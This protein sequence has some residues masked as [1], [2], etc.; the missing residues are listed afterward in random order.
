MNIELWV[1]GSMEIMHVFCSSY[2]E[3]FGYYGNK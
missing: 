1:D 2:V 3:K